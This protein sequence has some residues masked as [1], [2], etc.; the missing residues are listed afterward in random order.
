MKNEQSLKPVVVFAGNSIEVGL[1]KSL[2]E[3]AGIQAYLQDEIQGTIAPWV[4]S[5]GGAGAIKV[6]VS[7]ADYIRAKEIVDEYQQNI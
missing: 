3:N 1:V 2:L 4:I 7:S 6:L 5:P